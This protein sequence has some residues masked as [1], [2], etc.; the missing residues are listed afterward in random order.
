VLEIDTQVRNIGAF[1]VEVPKK[2]LTMDEFT[3]IMEQ[4]IMEFYLQ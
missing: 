2:T 1:E 4:R 3:E